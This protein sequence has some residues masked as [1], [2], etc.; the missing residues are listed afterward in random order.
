[1][2]RTQQTPKMSIQHEIKSL[3]KFN[4]RKWTY[5]A[6]HV[7]IH[8]AVTFSQR[9]IETPPERVATHISL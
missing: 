2:L 6:R 7:T 5:R 9:V 4:Q 3:T 1:M 8:I